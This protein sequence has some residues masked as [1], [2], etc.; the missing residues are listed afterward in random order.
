MFLKAEWILIV[1]Q[2]ELTEKNPESLRKCICLFIVMHDLLPI[3]LIFYFIF[4]I[5]IILIIFNIFNLWFLIHQIFLKV[6]SCFTFACWNLKLCVKITITL[7]WR[8]QSAD[9][10]VGGYYKCD[11]LKSFKLKIMALYLLFIKYYCLRNPVIEIH[12]F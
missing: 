5:F 1:I 9:V 8:L 10:P 3:F 6:F 2:A 11:Q 7:H 12:D 4:V